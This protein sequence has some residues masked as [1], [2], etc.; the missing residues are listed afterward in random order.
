MSIQPKA[1][2]VAAESSEQ[3]THDYLAAHPDFFEHHA[4][5]LGTLHLPHAT[6]G[7]VSLIERQISVL[8]QKNLKLEKKL[9][10]LIDVARA[11]DLLAAKIHELAMQLLA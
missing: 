6:G 4:T 2:Y 9:Q 8:R 11:N 3:A 1:K 5:L 10:E 7:T